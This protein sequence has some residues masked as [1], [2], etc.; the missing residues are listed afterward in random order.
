[1]DTKGHVLS[2]SLYM[3]HPAQA[4]DW[5]KGKL[6]LTAYGNRV[7]FRGYGSALELDDGD[8]CTTQ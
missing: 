1:M 5:W 3:K 8:G 4:E 6:E 7:P 2:D